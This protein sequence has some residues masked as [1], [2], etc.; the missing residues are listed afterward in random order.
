MIWPELHADLDHLSELLRDPGAEAPSDS[1]PYER[2]GAWYRACG[3]PVA[4][5]RW[6]LWSLIPPNP[7]DLRVALADVWRSCGELQRADVLLLG[8]QC[9]ETVALRLQQGQLTAAAELQAT[10]LQQASPLQESLLLRL[11]E[12]WTQ[13][14]GLAEARTLL[15]A[16]A[17]ANAPQGHTTGFCNAYAWLC[18][19]LNHLNEA[20]QWFEASLALNPQQLPQRLHLARLALEDFQRPDVAAHEAAQVL[21]LDPQHDWALKLRRRALRAM[22]AWGSLQVLEPRAIGPQLPAP[23]RRRLPAWL[24]QLQRFGAALPSSGLLRRPPSPL[25]PQE[26]ASAL[27]QV[28]A[29][30]TNADWLVW[31]DADGSSLALCGAGLASGVIAPPPKVWLLASPDP[32]LAQANLTAWLQAGLVQPLTTVLTW[33]QWDPELHGQARLLINCHP[34]SASGWLAQSSAI[35][36]RCTRQPGS[37]PW[38][39]APPPP[40]LAIENTKFAQITCLY[41]ADA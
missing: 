2:I 10:L 18:L 13:S 37:A 28:P 7:Q 27:S 25:D 29:D 6:Q 24:Q 12:L 17:A 31:G 38:R 32:W 5:G 40:E 20:A 22:G 36:L 21:A 23:Y 15:A 11:V 39:I 4:A 16:L 30:A 26:L 1:E 8:E 14:N 3:D 35:P 41:A 19:K 9:W 34:R 33:P